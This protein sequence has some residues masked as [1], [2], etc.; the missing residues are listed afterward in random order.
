MPSA[1]AVKGL[2]RLGM[3]KGVL[4]LESCIEMTVLFPAQPGT[5][6]KGRGTFFGIEEDEGEQLCL[7]QPAHNR[8]SAE[9][10]AFR[11]GRRALGSQ[12]A[13]ELPATVWE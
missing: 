4:R 11:R 2:E 1:A 13:V 12:P 3:A 5:L 10:R 7:K 8:Q 6:E 9:S